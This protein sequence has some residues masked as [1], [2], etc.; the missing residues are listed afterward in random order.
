MNR[1]RTPKPAKKPLVGLI[2]PG[3]GARGAYQLG[4]LQAIAEMGPEEGN[5]FPIM[6]GVSV[7][8]INATALASRADN[9]REAVEWLA[10]LWR[11]LRSSKVYRTDY[12]TIIRNGFRWFMALTFGGLGAANPKSLLDNTPLGELLAREIDFGRIHKA[13]RKGAVRAV[14][15]TASSYTQGKAITFFEARKGVQEWVRS[16][17]EGDRVKLGVN[18]VMGSVALPFV[19]P[20]QQIGYDYFGDGSLRLTA[21]LSPAIHFGAERILVIGSRDE[22]PSAIPTKKTEAG[23]PTFGEIAGSA[24]DIL[25]NDNLRE[26]TE[27]AE[28]VNRTVSLLSPKKRGKTPLRVVEIMTIRPSRDVRDIARK[29]VDHIPWTIRM[30]LKG[31]G[32]WGGRWQLPSYLMFEP[33]FLADLMELGYKDAMRRK[34]E[35]REF[36]AF[37]RAPEKAKRK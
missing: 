15:I 4:V 26:D 37:R 21:P 1:A 5:P 24:L 3:G 34:K 23:F 36:L 13:I 10:C 19:F 18:H 32:A 14:G 9:F 27:R 12:Q 6:V 2:L 28:R 17:R 22:K 8:A 16:R 31:V 35:L 30:L 7:G 33:A 11:N 20:P 25:F 29:Y